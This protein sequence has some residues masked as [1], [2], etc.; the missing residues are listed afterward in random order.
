M[1]IDTRYCLQ[2]NSTGKEKRLSLNFRDN[3]FS[4]DLETTGSASGGV[5]QKALAASI[6]RSELKAKN[7]I[8]ESTNG[9]RDRPFTG[10]G[11]SDARDRMSMRLETPAGPRPF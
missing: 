9:K 6:E 1:S 7:L 4:L 3:L 5:S 10:C 8:N 2:Y 11:A